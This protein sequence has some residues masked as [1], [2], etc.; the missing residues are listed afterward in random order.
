M[1]GF[2]MKFKHLTLF[3]FLIVVFLVAGCQ[4]KEV[5]ITTQSDLPQQITESFD[6]NDLVSKLDQ[7]STLINGKHRIFSGTPEFVGGR[8][9]EI[10]EPFLPPTGEQ[11]YQWSL[12]LQGKEKDVVVRISG[13]LTPIT[14]YEVGKFYQ[15]NTGDI[16]LSG[17]FSGVI[18]DHNFDKLKEVET[19]GCPLRPTGA[20]LKNSES[21]IKEQIVEDLSTEPEK[22]DVLITSEQRTKSWCEDG[23]P[24]AVFVDSITYQSLSNKIDRFVNDIENDINDKVFL[25]IVS[26]NTNPEDIRDKIRDFYKTKAIQGVIFVGDVPIV[27]TEFAAGFQGQSAFGAYDWCYVDT[28]TNYD[29]SQTSGK[30]VCS[31]QGSGPIKTRKLWYGRIIP[32]EENKVELLSSYFDR[33]HNYRTGSLTYPKSSL[34]YYDVETSAGSDNQ[35]LLSE[36]FAGKGSLY[37]SVETI[38]AEGVDEYN[39][40]ISGGSLITENNYLQSLKIPRELVLVNQHGTTSFHFPY[41]TADDIAET[42]PQALAYL[43]YSCSVGGFQDTNYLAGQYI[44]SGNGLIGIAHSTPILTNIGPEGTLRGPEDATTYKLLA[45]LSKG[46]SFGEAWTVSESSISG[47]I[48]GDPTLRLRE[49]KIAKVEVNPL[50]VRINR[51]EDIQEVKIKNVGDNKLEALT[52]SFTFSHAYNPEAVEVDFSLPSTILPSEE[53]TLRM[54]YEEDK[55]QFD[56]IGRLPLVYIGE[57]GYW[58]YPLSVIGSVS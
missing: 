1:D 24:V 42:K 57:E 33:N 41:V 27:Q 28:T 13:K 2:K 55:A 21:E 49:K 36:Y 6:C 56:F 40:I 26:T 11:R 30:W 4:D 3:L 14:P 29:F 43:F 47:S 8:L 53:K 37:D 58:I 9:V 15:L 20:T 45:L 38:S 23:C 48:L 7:H 10:S 51:A 34:F 32:P 17:Y 46:A 54:M 50:S 25:E 5:I 19:N 22:E 16:R 35:E 12:L 18:I 52:H 31:P 44:Y 39:Q